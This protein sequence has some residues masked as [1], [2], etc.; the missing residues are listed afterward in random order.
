M[1]RGQL[2][3]LKGEH[4]GAV[5]EAQRVLQEKSGLYQR[6]MEE[7]E[8]AVAEGQERARVQAQMEAMAREAETIRGEVER[9]KG[10]ERELREQIAKREHNITTAN[11]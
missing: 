8:R 4:I 3:E 10:V 2:E 7:K 1:A 9:A 11:K 6:L 5:K